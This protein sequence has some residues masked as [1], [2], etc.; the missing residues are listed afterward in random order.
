MAEQK[1]TDRHHVIDYIEITV[2]DMAAAKAFYTAA[3]GWQFKDYGP[4]YSGIQGVE[5]EMGGLAQGDE[6]TTG[7]PLVILYS[8]DLDATLAAVRLAGGAIT[9]EP[10]D[11]PGGRRFHFT[12]PSGN[13]LAVWTQV[14]AS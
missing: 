2:R 8:E 11:F 7:G 4:G 5:R 6:V 1:S 9:T 14:S 10:F 12:D 3:F 13:Q